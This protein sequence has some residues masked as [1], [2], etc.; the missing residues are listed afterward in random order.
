MELRIDSKKIMKVLIIAA[1]ILTV[2]SLAG[3][4]YRFYG[5]SEGYLVAFFDLDHEWNLPT[6]YVSFI[7]LFCSLLLAIIC[8]AKK[9][10]NDRFF[11]HWLFLAFIFFI[12]ALDET[13]VFH[14]KAILPL[15]Y[16]LNARGILYYTW[17]VPGGL[18][19]VAFFLAYLKFLLHLSLY[20]RQDIF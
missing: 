9:K 10:N 2:A 11:Y 18:F 7:L 4:I 20:Y 16:L 14:E 17:V 5:G 8:F 15:R 1:V 13:I 6:F 3:Q 19:L 12:I